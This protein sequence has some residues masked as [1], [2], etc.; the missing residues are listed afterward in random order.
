M[1]TK[2]STNLD[3]TQKDLGEEEQMISIG[4]LNS[5]EHEVSIQDSIQYY[6]TILDCQPPPS[7]QKQFIGSEGSQ[8]P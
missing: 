2:P 6:L 5:S 1:F 7:H 3:C 4:P 8:C